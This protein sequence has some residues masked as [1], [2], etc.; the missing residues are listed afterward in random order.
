MDQL[1]GNNVLPNRS[2]D[3]RETLQC[4]TVQEI[5]AEMKGK[6]TL[7]RQE[8]VRKDLLIKRICVKA[9]PEELH[10]LK[11]TAMCKQ[12]Q[13]G[14]CG[15]RGRKRKEQHVIREEVRA[16]HQL[17][18]RKLVAIAADPDFY[19]CPRTHN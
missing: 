12:K 5:L 19:N 8:R 15:Q 13:A 6:V 16:N 18:H 9:A 3:L 17:G 4:L 11:E 10:K 1:T 7:S 14:T 2:G